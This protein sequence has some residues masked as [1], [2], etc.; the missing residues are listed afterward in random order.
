MT[1]AFERIAVAVD[2]SPVGSKT[3]ELAVGL[4]SRYGATVTVI[5]VREYERYEGDDVDMG[6]PITA[7]D[8][9]EQ[10]LAAFTEAGVEATG[11]IRRVRSNETAEQIV[12]VAGEAEVD[13]IVMG[14]RGM[15]EW[16]SLLLG[17]VANKVV[18]HATCPV[19][20]VR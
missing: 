1:A 10:T 8:L 2:G 15:T 3:V 16:K 7:E 6:P 5:H 18:H 11:V 14:T 9:V 4:A 12:N 17:G 13:L 19:L 20:L